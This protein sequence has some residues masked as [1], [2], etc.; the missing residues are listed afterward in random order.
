MENRTDGSTPAPGERLSSGLSSLRLNELLHEVTDRLTEIA[1]GRDQL[2]GLLDAVVGVASGLE[3][4]AT[5]RRIVEAAVALVDAEYGALGVI[6]ADRSL[7]QFVYTGIDEAARQR[8][9]HLPEGHGILGLLID[10]PRPVR[11]HRLADHP[12]SYGFPPNHPPMS[13]FLGVPVRVRDEVF[14]NL[15]LTEK[16]GGDFT[17]D[18]EVVVQALAAA[19]GVAIENARLFESTR[20][21]Q[22]WLEA[23]NEIRAALLSGTDADD[24]LR[25]VAARA[26]ELA[27]ADAVLLLLP[28]PAAPA[29]RLVVTVAD[30]AHAADLRGLAT[31]IAGSV[32]GRVYSSGQ[33]E[34][35][36]DVTDSEPVFADHAGYGPGL[37]LPLGGPAETGVLLVANQ[38]GAAPLSAE[39]TELTAAFA[40][41]AALALRLAEAQRAHAQLALYADRDRIA[42]DLHDQVIQR[43]FATGMSLQSITRQVPSAAQA[44]LHR[45]VDDL[46]HTIREIRT[47]IYALQAPAGEPA[48]LRQQILA[49]LE[50]ATSGSGLELDLHVTGPVDTVVPPQVAAHALAVLREAATNVVRHA[51]A[52][53]VTVTVSAGDRLCIQVT[54]DGTGIPA[55][56]RRSGLTNLADRAT[57]LH[58]TLT[59]EPGPVGTGTRLTW[60]APLH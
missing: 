36:V 12:R 49:V 4:A 46:D 26:R 50:E 37:V 21:R 16:R 55:D 43:L 10:D 13:T 17:A 40:G 18:D 53:T 39:A 9:G 2:H 44:K 3:L 8:I 29:D 6:G 24:A 31:P 57:Q 51:K 35:V 58:G 60:N 47:T 11:L 48:P 22:R 38:L 54:D 45:A 33:P 15:Y 30:G 1:A 42:R 28:D 52:S 23:S 20:R 14:G 41:Q 19:A 25:L 59:T 5:L 32:T 27:A 56:G 34:T 7:D